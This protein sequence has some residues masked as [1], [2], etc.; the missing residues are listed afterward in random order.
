MNRILI[1]AVL[2]S[3]VL[4]P[5]VSEAGP[6]CGGSGKASGKAMGAG[7]GCK[8]SAETADAKAS[9]DPAACAAK[10]G[11]SCTGACKG[12]KASQ[13]SAAAASADMVGKEVKGIAGQMQL[14]PL[15]TCVV[16]GEKLGSRGEPFDYDHEGRLVRLCCQGCVG[17]FQESPAVYLEKL[18]AAVIAAQS[19]S[20]PLT[21]CP[22]SGMK[23]GGMGEPVDYVYQGQLVRFCCSGCIDKFNEDPSAAMAMLEAARSEA[24][25]TN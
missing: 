15:D 22:V 18:D 16:S 8:A 14:Y 20:Y 19:E 13:A 10:C 2:L 24:L 1:L 3:F 25:E 6:G 21:T 23:L 12:A 4:V 9:C 7:S 5:V 17:P 11:A